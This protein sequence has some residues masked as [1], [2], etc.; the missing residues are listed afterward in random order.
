MIQVN[1]Q[2]KN[3][4]TSKKIISNFR[5]KKGKI[6][7]KLKYWKPTT[8][9]IVK[10]TIHK[11]GKLGFSRSAISRLKLNQDTYAK[12]AINESDSKDTNLYL[13]IVKEIDGETLKV[14][15]AGE[16]YYLNTKDFFNEWGIDFRK[17]RII[18]DIV[19]IEYEGNK[20]FKLIKREKER[21]K[22]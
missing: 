6:E 19:D 22:K 3:N 16:Y 7:M 4:L 5:L 8:T 13:L 15:K 14:N 17:K 12:L 10:A 2:R 21:T 9:G 1:A 18:Y 11:S 20:I